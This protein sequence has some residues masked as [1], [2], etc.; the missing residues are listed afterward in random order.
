MV[1]IGAEGAPIEEIELL[2]RMNRPAVEDFEKQRL[3]YRK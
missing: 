3:R 2:R 1:V